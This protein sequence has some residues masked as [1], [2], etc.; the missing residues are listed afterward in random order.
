M[1]APPP[2]TPPRGAGGPGSPGAAADSALY[3]F[4]SR[5]LIVGVGLSL[6]L[7]AAGVLLLAARHVPLAV[8]QVGANGQTGR[9]SGTWLPLADVAPRALAGDPNGILDLGVLMLFATPTLRVVA[10]I[11]VFAADREY[12]YVAISCAILAL[13]ALSLI[14]AFH[15]VG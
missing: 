9:G 1:S 14:V 2:S 4:L 12:R 15:S 13:L 6:A 5:L 10:A 7:M 3:G 8:P 11:V